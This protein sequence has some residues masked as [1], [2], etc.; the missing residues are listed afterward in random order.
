MRFFS[1]WPYNKYPPPPRY[2]TTFSYQ[3]IF[4]PL[5]L[6]LSLSL[7]FSLLWSSFLKPLSLLSFLE[8]CNRQKG[9]ANTRLEKENV[10]NIDGWM[11]ENERHLIS[12]DKRNYWNFGFDSKEILN[13]KQFRKYI[14]VA[15]GS[16]TW[17][18]LKRQYAPSTGTVQ[19]Q[20][21]RG[22]SNKK[23]LFY[24]SDS[25]V[26]WMFKR[27]KWMIH[28]SHLK[29]TPTNLISIHVIPNTFQSPLHCIVSLKY[30]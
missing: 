24:P 21:T 16:F 25:H 28:E 30:T 12:L 6:S 5:S 18:H 3:I 26:I 4:S 10:L 2:R 27:K 17:T 22:H 9:V 29:G 19:I 14:F 23:H 13:L 15:T 7:S 8:K 1:I 20:S 11:T